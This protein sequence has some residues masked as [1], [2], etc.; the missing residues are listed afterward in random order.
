MQEIVT[1]IIELHKKKLFSEALLKINSFEINNELNAVILNLKGLTLFFLNLFDES[2]KSYEKALTLIDQSNKNN[3]ELFISILNNKGLANLRYANYNDAIADFKKVLEY[4]PNFFQAVN[5]LG[6]AHESLGNKTES[7]KYYSDANNLNYHFAPARDNLINSL[8]FLDNIEKNENK[9]VKTDLQIRNNNFIYDKI[10]KIDQ[11]NIFSTINIADK[12][13]E[14]TIGHIEIKNTQTFRRGGE[15]LN[16]E[17][18]KKIFDEK[19]IIPKYCF[20]CFKILIEPENILD[21]IRLHIIFDNFQF[22]NGNARK[23]MIEMRKGVSGVYKGFIYCKSLKEAEE[24]QDQ[25]STTLKSNISTN[26]R[27]QIKRGCTEYLSSYPNYKD[28]KKLMI[29]NEDWKDDENSIDQQFPFL[30]NN[31]SNRRTR[32]GINLRDILTFRNWIYFAYL[33]NDQTYKLVS[34]KIYKTN[35]IEKKVLN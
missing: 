11:T 31:F 21:L 6:A 9:I 24:I 20:S 19:N 3:N 32:S 15:N 34:E 4:N 22:K 33:K 8:T 1:S 30:K 27:Y 13:I 18:H 10:K 26:I 17:R 35:F 5:N 23:C 2:I 16:C 29:Y 12:I 25:I 14:D 28:L 7:F